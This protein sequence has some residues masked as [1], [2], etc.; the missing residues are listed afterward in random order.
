VVERQAVHIRT[1]KD[2]IDQLQSRI[3]EL[4]SELEKSEAEVAA[5]RAKLH[6]KVGAR[7]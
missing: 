3:F 1:L 2:E 6:G 7:P 4:E 5:L